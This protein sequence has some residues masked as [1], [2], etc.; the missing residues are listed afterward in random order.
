M[1]AIIA[2]LLG[3]FYFLWEGFK[4]IEALRWLLVIGGA[5]L[6]CSLPAISNWIIDSFID[7]P[8]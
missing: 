8:R 3:I 5:I 1:L 4:D 6:G 7:P 2:A